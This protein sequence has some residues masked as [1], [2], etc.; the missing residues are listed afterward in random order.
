MNI[1]GTGLSGLLG[2]SVVDTLKDNFS[3]TN[4]S[5]ETGVD[6][7]DKTALE[8]AIF[9][10]DA[11]WVFHFAARTDV[12]QAEKEK[13]Q[14]EKSSVWLVNVEATDSIA[15]L[16]NKTGKHMLYISTDYVFS[17]TKERYTEDDVPDPVGWYA[18]TKYEGEKRVSRLGNYGLVVR[19]ANPYG[20]KESGK[21]DFVHKITHDL[22]L[23]MTIKAPS[24]QL[25]V[26]TFIPDIA[27]AIQ[28]LLHK[29]ACGTYQ[30]VGDEAFSP[31]QAAKEIARTL[32][33][34]NDL[35][36]EARFEEFFEGR[37]SRPFHAVLSND[38]IK[39]LGARM[40][41]FANGLETIFSK[42]K[43]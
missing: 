36:Q 42:E 16:C 18:K 28:L 41:S 24:D 11:P 39:K 34:S 4:L 10:S 38:K 19:I 17:G 12:D 15:S 26:P 20:P 14:K 35:V 3:F 13:D 37:A 43:Q 5:L 25:F 40:T 2:T 1:L 27:A 29:N 32:H 22:K 21:K 8:K 30:V 33:V 9:S 31:Y 7:T 6:I 23:G